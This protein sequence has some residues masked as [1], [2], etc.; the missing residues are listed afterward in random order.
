MLFKLNCG[1]YSYIFFEENTNFH[2]WSKTA[3]KLL[4]KLQKLMIICW[5]NLYHIQKFLK[6]IHN[7]NIKPRSYNLRDKIWLNCKYIKTKSNW[8]FEAKFFNPFSVLY[9]VNK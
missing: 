6:Q 4:V 2:F 7:K 5:K 3:D 1:Y 9:L 8:K